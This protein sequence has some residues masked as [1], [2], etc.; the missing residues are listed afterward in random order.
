MLLFTYNC[1][2]FEATFFSTFV[3]VRNSIFS[4]NFIFHWQYFSNISS[5]CNYELSFKPNVF[6]ASELNVILHKNSVL[7]CQKYCVKTF[8][9]CRLPNML[10]I[11]SR[12][13]NQKHF[14]HIKSVETAHH[15]I[16]SPFIVVAF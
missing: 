5:K 13:D 8:L 10:N 15:N 9:L 3:S 16:V 14:N 2:I 7:N 6:L 1:F 12:P 11:C 4:D